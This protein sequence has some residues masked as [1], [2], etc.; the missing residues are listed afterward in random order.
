MPQRIAGINDSSD[1]SPESESDSPTERARKQT[2]NA[3]IK[4]KRNKTQKARDDPDDGAPV[5]PYQVAKNKDPLLAVT[6]KSPEWVEV[7]P[8]K[9]L[10]LREPD[11]PVNPYRA[12]EHAAEDEYDSVKNKAIRNHQM[13]QAQRW[14][15]DE[16]DRAQRMA[17]YQEWEIQQRPLKQRLQQQNEAEEAQAKRTYM[18]AH[19][20][21]EWENIVRDH[22]HLGDNTYA[23][24]NYIQPHTTAQWNSL[25]RQYPQLKNNEVERQNFMKRHTPEE[26]FAMYPSWRNNNEEKEAFINPHTE[27]QWIA[28]RDRTVFLEMRQRHMSRI[29][30]IEREIPRKKRAVINQTAASEWLDRTRTVT[31]GYSQENFMN[32][33]SKDQW[34]WIKYIRDA[35]NTTNG[36]QAELEDESFFRLPHTKAEWD[37]VQQ[38]KFDLLQIKKEEDESRRNG[39]H[40]EWLERV[41]T[42]TEQRSRRIKAVF[43]YDQLVDSLTQFRAALQGRLRLVDA[44][45]RGETL[46]RIM[47]A[48]TFESDKARFLVL[49]SVAA[50][51]TLLAQPMDRLP[52]LP[53]ST[54]S[55]G[56]L[57]D[58]LNGLLK[59]Y[60]LKDTVA[61]AVPLTFATDAS[62]KGP[63]REFILK[64][65]QIPL[66]EGNLFQ[67]AI[68]FQLRSLLSVCRHWWHETHRTAAPAVQT[69]IQQNQAA[70]N[71]T[72][73]DYLSDVF[74]KPPF[75]TEIADRMRPMVKQI[76][77]RIVDLS[78]ASLENQIDIKILLAFY[79]CVRTFPTAFGDF[80]TVYFYPGQIGSQEAKIYRPSQK[81]EPGTPLAQTLLQDDALNQLLR[82]LHVSERPDIT[83][84]EA[85]V[86]IAPYTKYIL[87]TEDTKNRREAC[88]AQQCFGACF[89]DLSRGRKMEQIRALLAQ[90]RTRKTFGQLKAELVGRYGALVR[91]PFQETTFATAATLFDVSDGRKVHVDTLFRLGPAHLANQL[92][93]NNSADIAACFLIENVD[94][95]IDLI[96]YPSEPHD[97]P[98]NSPT[99]I[100]TKVRRKEMNIKEQRKEQ[101][102]ENPPVIDFTEFVQELEKTPDLIP[103]P[104]IMTKMKN[105]LKLLNIKFKSDSNKDTLE[106]SFREQLTQLLRENGPHYFR[107]QLAEIERNAA[108]GPAPKPAPTPPAPAPTPPTPAPTPP[109]PA[110]TPATPPAPAPTP[111]A[112]PAPG[113]KG[114]GKAAPTPPGMVWDFDTNAYVPITLVPPQYI[115]VPRQTQK[116]SDSPNPKR[117]RK[118]DSPDENHDG[119]EGP[120]PYDP[121][122]VIHDSPP[123][124]PG[125]AAKSDSPP[126]NSYYIPGDA[127]KSDSPPYNSYY[128]PGDA[129]ASDSPPYKNS[130]EISHTPPGVLYWPQPISQTPPGPFPNPSLATVPRKTK[131]PIPIKPAAATPTARP[132]LRIVLPP[133]R[134]YPAWTWEPKGGTTTK[135]RPT[136]RLN[137]QRRGSRKRKASGAKPRVSKR[138]RA[139][140]NSVRR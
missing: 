28:H 19:H 4:E 25:V 110:P 139:C 123:Y 45:K 91:T 119:D 40:D 134:P 16:D 98:Q 124:I 140:R 18:E 99:F 79:S 20:P 53:P 24:H 59:D 137:R 41:R 111:P 46:N 90:G 71:R 35:F 129:V 50:T 48:F 138:S 115:L 128:I 131:P 39:T 72:V 116:K 51:P 67:T 13:E 88:Q 62:L 68:T 83:E 21:A 5:V 30:G 97:S 75:T 38:H 118:S 10:A 26:W 69:T 6:D 43:P 1:S 121:E 64:N 101:R 89:E 44:F 63:V 125:D 34:Q 109:T 70:L 114:K 77:S 33:I 132:A 56:Q 65:L 80:T 42:R 117:P 55:L 86:T 29:A 74:E 76:L 107:E 22:P 85:H 92:G 135:G 32:E 66:M 14:A 60:D 94:R 36:R 2:K 102:K 31:C 73:Q 96:S 49:V 15:L 11:P 120:A 9:R 47:D 78:A 130:D 95:F 104:K 106:A 122:E 37:M 54:T 127:A 23:Y 3:K 136:R 100:G 82:R 108:E 27:Q 52:E 93:Y 133:Y 81:I 84:Y 113:P 126:Y 112:P 58:Y 105:I 7:S 17:A 87:R 57:V 8:R 103:V 61:V 12:A